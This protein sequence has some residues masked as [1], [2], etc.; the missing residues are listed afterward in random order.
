LTAD[1]GNNEPTARMEFW[2]TLYERPL[3]SNDEA[4]HG[5]LL[6]WEGN[7][8][9][10]DYAGRV[11]AL[12]DRGWLAESFDEPADQAVSRGTVAV[13]LVQALELHGGLS[14]HLFGPVPRYAVRELHHEGIY[15]RSSPQQTFSGA[16]FVS[17]IGRLED[18]VRS[19]EVSADEPAAEEEGPE[20]EG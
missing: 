18:F 16:Q 20:D 8:P 6:S 15:P 10:A 19:R 11:R 4:F 1:L 2:H 9:A 13:L 5:L 14:M 7:D 17:L 3:T 12:K